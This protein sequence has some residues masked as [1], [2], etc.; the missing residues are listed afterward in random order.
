MDADEGY[1]PVVPTAQY[2]TLIRNTVV[3]KSSTTGCKASVRK[4]G[5]QRGGRRP[6]AA[7]ER[8]PPM[9]GHDASDL[10]SGEYTS[11]VGNR[12]DSPSKMTA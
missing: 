2:C 11:G 8:L 12:S 10:E 3:P 5:W 6:G 4:A 7:V 9:P 1:R